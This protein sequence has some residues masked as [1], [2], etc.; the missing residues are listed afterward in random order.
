MLFKGLLGAVLASYNL[1]SVLILD[2]HTHFSHTTLLLWAPLE[3]SSKKGKISVTYK[4]QM[5]G[6][7][8]HFKCHK[9]KKC[10]ESKRKKAF[11]ERS[12]S[13]LLPL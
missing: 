2:P 11:S 12:Y 9:G 8:L 7:V 6:T 10:M 1:P 13:T 4:L 3:L 5:I